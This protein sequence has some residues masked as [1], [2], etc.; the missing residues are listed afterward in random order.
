MCL[1]KQ[2]PDFSARFMGSLDFVLP[3]KK[4]KKAPVVYHYQDLGEILHA[5]MFACMD[6]NIYIHAF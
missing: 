6:M 1:S 3:V 5:Q 2:C 4:K